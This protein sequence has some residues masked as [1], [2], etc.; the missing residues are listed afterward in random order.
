M[1]FDDYFGGQDDQMNFDPDEAEQIE[2]DE[3]QKQELIQNLKASGTAAGQFQFDQRD[4]M[5]D[6]ED[7]FNDP[8]DQEEDEDDPLSTDNNQVH[9]TR[10]S[11]FE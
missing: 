9:L 4:N 2:I 7:F 10:Q 8:L 6:D 3:H 1:D 11:L 5:M